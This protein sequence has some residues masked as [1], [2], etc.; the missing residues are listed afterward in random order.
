MREFD[1]SHGV[2]VFPDRLTRRDIEFD[3]KITCAALV[4]RQALLVSR[5]FEAEDTGSNTH[6]DW[7]LWRRVLEAGYVA[8]KQ[9]TP[10]LYRKHGLSMISAAATIPYAERADL[11]RAEVTLFSPLSGR[12]GA[13]EGLCEWLEAQSWPRSQC[14]LVLA[15]TSQS[16]EFHGRVR[17]WL[18]GS[19]Y[20]DVRL[21]RQSVG[22]ERLAELPRRA[23]ESAVTLACQRLYARMARELA[24]PYVLVVEDDVVPPPDALARLFES[25]DSRTAAVS[26]AYLGRHALPP[27]LVAWSGG[28]AVPIAAREPLAVSGSGFGCLLL[29]RAVL[30]GE[31]FATGTGGRS[32]W[33]DH[34]FGARV[35][36]RGLRWVLDPRVRCAHL[37]APEWPS[38]SGEWRVGSGEQE[39][40]AIVAA[41][42]Y[43]RLCGCASGPALDC[44]PG[45]KRPGQRVA[46]AECRACLD[47]QPP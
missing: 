8:V 32:H 19:G 44:G 20:P 40:L 13:W 41:C 43:A 42:P 3:N 12:P 7:R 37:G 24:T 34:A 38:R 6:A 21:Y 17:S 33:Y 47:A 16:D 25:L 28:G 35:A 45:G 46:V 10:L 11:A 5:A 9:P 39:A 30:A 15:D 14:R 1:Q 22:A 4:T 36:A 27:A 23:H 31:T 26:G 18:L 2:G 29:R